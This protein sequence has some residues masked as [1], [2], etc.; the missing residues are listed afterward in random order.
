MLWILGFLLLFIALLIPILAIVLDSPVARNLLRGTDPSRSDE[1]LKRIQALEEEV[2]E[3]GTALETL[4][5]ET[6]FIQRLL[7]NPEHPDASKRL[8]PPK[9]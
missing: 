8:S 4:K 5:D 9:P 2:S 7:E 3:L 1:I 6:E